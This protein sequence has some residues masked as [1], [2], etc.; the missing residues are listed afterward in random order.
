MK[1]LANGTLGKR[2]FHQPDGCARL[3]LSIDYKQ[4]V[5]VDRSDAC[6][7][8]RGA[9]ERVLGL[10]AIDGRLDELCETERRSG[11]PEV[12]R[13]SNDVEELPELSLRRCW[14]VPIK[15]GR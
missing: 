2:F 8:F 15:P 6:Q 4:P 1:D 14:G 11:R 3:V 5:D 12:V 9:R 13:L 10:G 7:D